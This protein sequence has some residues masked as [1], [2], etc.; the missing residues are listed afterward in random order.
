MF[1]LSISEQEKNSLRLSMFCERKVNWKFAVKIDWNE[2]EIIAEKKKES[3]EQTE[4]ENKRVK[5]GKLFKENV[6]IILSFCFTST[7]FQ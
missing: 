7:S 1:F 3:E 6:Q 2:T 5:S 4:I